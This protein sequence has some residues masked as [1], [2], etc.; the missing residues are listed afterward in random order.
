MKIFST[1]FFVCCIG[2]T[3]A[4]GQSYKEMMNDYS[5]NFYDVV[6]KAEIHFKTNATGKGSGFKGYMRWKNENESKFFPSGD[7]S[8]VSPYFIE[9]AYNRIKKETQYLGSRAA[10]NPDWIELGPWDANVVTSHYSEGIGRVETFYVYPKN[11]NIMYLGSRSGGFW[12][13][14]DGGSNWECST[15]TM[16]ATGVNILDASD[17][18]PDS[19]LINLQ[20]AQNTYTQ[21]I[22]YS[23]DGGK[24]WL[25]SNFNP[26]NLGWGGL[27]RTGRVRWI[28][29]SP[30]DSKLVLVGTDRGIY[31]S[32]NFMQTYT[33]VVSSGNFTQ[34]EFHPTNANVIYVYNNVNNANRNI[35]QISR[36]AGLTFSPSN[37][38][39]QNNNNN[40]GRLS[41]SKDCPNCV[42]FSS[43]NGVWKSLNE[44]QDFTF[45][46]NPGQGGHG[47]AVNDVD[48]SN[49]IYGYVDL[50]ASTDGGKNFNQVTYWSTGNSSH[51]SSNYIHADMRAAQSINGVFYVGTDGYFAKSSNKGVSWTRLNDGT[52][53]REFYRFG[54]SQSDAWLSM[55]GSQDNGTSIYKKEGWIEWNGGD[56]M[57]AVVQALNS[58]WMLGSWQY[59]NR[60]RTTNGGQSRGGASHGNT[61]DWI[62][63][64]LTDPNHQMN[65]YSFGENVFKSEQFGGNWQTL[66]NVGFRNGS[67][68]SENTKHAAIAYNNSKII[69]AS[70]NNKMMLSK[71]A[72][73][74]FTEIT[75]DLPNTNS[76]SWI[77]FD[78]NDDNTIIL[79]YD[80]Y[81]NENKRIY[82]SRDLC[83]TWENI[84]YNL[85]DMPLRT[86]VID[87]TDS[88]YI[89]VGG[90][91]GVYYKSMNGGSWNL[92]SEKL[93]TVSIRELDIQW[94]TNTLRAVA[95]GRGMWQTKLVDRSD[96]PEITKITM[97]VAPTTT[98]PK[99]DLPMEVTA[100]V[101][102]K[103]LLKK[104]YLKW[105]K[106]TAN[107]VNTIE[108]VQLNGDTF[109]A[110]SDIPEFPS[111]TNIYFKVFAEAN[112]G[113]LSESA[114]LHYEYRVCT[115]RPIVRAIAS[116]TEVC[117]GESFVLNGGGGVRYTWNNGGENGIPIIADNSVTYTVKGYDGLNCASIDSV[118]VTA[119]TVATEVTVL[120]Q[121]LQANVVSTNYQWLDCDNNWMPIRGETNRSFTD[122]AGGRFS[123]ELEQNSCIDTSVCYLILGD[124]NLVDINEVSIKQIYGNE[125]Q[126]FPNPTSGIIEFKGLSDIGEFTLSVYTADGKLVQKN[127]S[128]TTNSLVLDISDLHSGLY[129]VELKSATT[130]IRKRILK[131]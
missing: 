23:I 37:A 129:L 17:S 21:G 52:A 49:L 34:I 100:V 10:Q 97:N 116:K 105:S 113:D 83:K 22:Y 69:L 6:A 15:D 7:R 20:N 4:S 80:R 111:Q 123:V 130:V 44:G 131:E 11:T 14:T 114:K 77:A 35:I 33:R 126:I 103:T 31:R 98:Q 25:L 76:L 5:Y 120:K 28:K 72:G 108:F 2:L 90:E 60:N 92:Y 27:G 46:S 71:D 18:D 121:T 42:Y 51:I 96:Y 115:S 73:V 118:T 38:I 119:D 8:K 26:T 62:A 50:T 43:N 87:F 81:Q 110:K 124:S 12:R 128:V 74:S 63:P 36:N 91:R 41:V 68:N 75:S 40:N 47:F 112:S 54:L 78:P 107:Y 55:A 102:S 70:R 93:P 84:S 88:S 59:G 39:P 117:R 13:T 32:T 86:A 67:G 66:G 127:E 95:W 29:I 56:G 94:A 125:I 82:V 104:V 122:I 16:I 30:Y 64:M 53:I 85:S 61:N 89:Y 45:L 48:T 3:A 1:L 19:V 99:E 101:T 109:V 79:T 65:V 57:E 106:D 9:N 24:S 58:D